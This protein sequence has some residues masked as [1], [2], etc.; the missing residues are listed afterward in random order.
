MET[1]AVVQKQASAVSMGI[2]DMKMLARELAES[3][4]VPSCYA[5]APENIIAALQLGKEL[6]VTPMVMLSNSFPVNNKIGFSTDLLVGLAKR[7]EEWG[8]MVVKA[9]NESCTVTIKRKFNNGVLEEFTSTFSVEMAKKAGLWKAGGGW[10]KYPQRMCKHRATGF[11]LRDAFPDVLSGMYTK[12]E[13]EAS[14][15]DAE[16]ATDA[17]EDAPLPEDIIIGEADVV[18][19]G[20]KDEQLVALNAAMKEKN[21]A[22]KAVQMVRT[23][24]REVRNA[25]KRVKDSLFK[26]MMEEITGKKS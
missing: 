10:D 2:R 15:F 13:L 3:N 4:M 23:R 20:P 9:T 25:S 7:H 16:E 11:A 24:W 19:E 12:E 6:G 18:E 5:G 1:K 17:P 14:Q 22:P 26:V 21:Y 8:G